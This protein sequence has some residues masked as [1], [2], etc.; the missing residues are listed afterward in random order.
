M[1][2]TFASEG[3]RRLTLTG[4]D[5]FGT[6]GTD[7]VDVTVGPMPTMPVVTVMIDAP[8]NGAELRADVEYALKGNAHDTGN[9]IFSEFVWRAAGCGID[10][11]IGTTPGGTTGSLPFLFPVKNSA[12]MWRPAT[13]GFSNCDHVELKLAVTTV[14]GSTGQSP[15]MPATVI[16]TYKLQ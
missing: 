12:L 5:D 15:E 1:S 3:A 9:R 11:V 14:D 4:T 13:T 2:V 8:G 6:S 7:T 16:K 10:Q